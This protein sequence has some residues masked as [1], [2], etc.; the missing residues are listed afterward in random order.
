MSTRKSRPHRRK[1]RAAVR[2]GPMPIP[3]KAHV[4]DPLA[5]EPDRST[6]VSEII[7]RADRTEP[8]DQFSRGQ[9]MLALSYGA[10]VEP[11]AVAHILAWAK[12]I[13]GPGGAGIS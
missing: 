3:A 2:H 12:R 11:L 5:P 13:A 4:F 1:T 10:D 8:L 6:F 7:T 9:L